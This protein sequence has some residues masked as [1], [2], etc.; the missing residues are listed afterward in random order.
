MDL[1]LGV[2]R[3]Q[4]NNSTTKS[5]YLVH[6]FVLPLRRRLQ[7]FYETFEHCLFCLVCSCKTN[8][9][10]NAFLS[11]NFKN[12]FAVSLFQHFCVPCVSGDLIYD[13][14][15]ISC[16]THIEASCRNLLHRKNS[17]FSQFVVQRSHY[18]TPEEKASLGC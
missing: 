13:A 3:K 7:M 12:V 18:F 16:K 11:N 10:I 5:A 9:L 6:R 8:Q 4:R 1:L 2:C 14:F 15:F 17:A